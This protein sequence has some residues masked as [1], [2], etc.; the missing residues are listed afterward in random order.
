MQVFT[1]EIRHGDLAWRITRR[2]RHFTALHARLKAVIPVDALP[3]L[4]P[5][6]WMPLLERNYLLRRQLALANYLRG[7][8]MIEQ[9]EAS[10]PMLSFLGGASS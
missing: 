1:I 6:R 4:P 3:Q 9:A 8:L 2:Y 5:R 10:V 7:L